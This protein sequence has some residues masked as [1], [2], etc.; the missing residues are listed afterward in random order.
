[1][2]FFDSSL[3]SCHF[4]LFTEVLRKILRSLTREVGFAA[5]NR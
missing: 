2:A 1:L 3:L 4:R 5:L